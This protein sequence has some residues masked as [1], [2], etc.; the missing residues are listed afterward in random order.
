MMHKAQ[1][2]IAF[3]M[4]KPSFSTE[5]CNLNHKKEVK[6]KARSD[7]SFLEHSHSGLHRFEDTDLGAL[8]WR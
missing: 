6:M 4:V 7:N 8:E 2:A 5:T 1:T 3:A